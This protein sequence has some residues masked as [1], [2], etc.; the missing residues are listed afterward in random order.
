M[1]STNGTQ[2]RVIAVALDSTDRDLIHKWADEG[3]LPNVKKCLERGSY[4]E[5]ESTAGLM[6]ATPWPSMWLSQWPAEHGFQCWMQWRPDLM[7][8]LRPD[9]SWLPLTPFYRRLGPL[10]KR[11]IAIDIPMVYDP[12]PMEGIEVASWGSYDKL[13]D[14]GSHPKSMLDRLARDYVKLPIGPEFGELRGVEAQLKLRDQ[15]IAGT[16]RVGDA[17]RDLMKNEPWDLFIAAFGATHRAGHDFWDR[18]SIKEENPPEERGRKYDNALRDIY[19]AVDRQLG[20]L[21]DVA[22]QDASLLVFSLH[23]MRKSTSRYRIFGDMLDRVV[24]DKNVDPGP[25][26]PGGGGMLKKLRNAIP[27]EWRSEVKRRLPKGV[28]DLMTKFWA[29]R[30]KRDWSQIKAFAPLGDLEGYVRIN[31]KGREK[32]GVIEPQDFEAFRQKIIDGLLSF[33]GQKTG[34]PAVKEVIKSED[35]FKDVPEEKRKDL[36]DLIVVWHDSS[37]ADEPVLESKQYGKIYWPTPGKCPDGRS[38]HHRPTGWLVAIGDGIP[39]GD[40]F[41]ST[42]SI[43]LAPTIMKLLGVEPFEDFAGEPMAAI[44]H[45]AAEKQTAA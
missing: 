24:Y 38:G 40:T 33:K 37:V 6:V 13:C 1:E 22:P 25:P 29:G 36:P 2:K 8:E 42:H 23:G 4:A 30:S 3:H 45:G 16:E 32:E 7:D 12:V 5:M 18:S 19:A 10:G 17:M 39:A 41:E 28:Q 35:L 44:V 27:V 14:V 21:M 43:H 31:L 26:Q 20:K 15:L 11:T 9:P 34:M